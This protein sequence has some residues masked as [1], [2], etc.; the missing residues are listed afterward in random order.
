MRVKQNELWCCIVG[1]L[2]LET[3]SISPTF[4]FLSVV[5]SN[6]DRRPHWKTLQKTSTCYYFIIH[7]LNI[8][9]ELLPLYPWATIFILFHQSFLIPRMIYRL[10]IDFETLTLLEMLPVITEFRWTQTFPPFLHLFLCLPPFSPP[11]LSF[12]C[13]IF[14]FQAE[15]IK[16][17]IRE[18]WKKFEYYRTLRKIEIFFFPVSLSNYSRGSNRLQALLF[19]FFFLTV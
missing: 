3:N 5:Y 10:L 16:L 8:V 12:L 7:D 14:A 4:C 15:I 6:T 17:T 19:F 18:W 9:I 11:R 1:F 13:L 2:N